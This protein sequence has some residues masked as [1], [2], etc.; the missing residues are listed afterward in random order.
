MKILHLID[1]MSSGGAQSL[2]LELSLVQKQ[3]GHDVSV[4]QLSDSPDRTF[5]VRLL[6]NSIPIAAL[7]KG[8]MYN[9]AH[10][11][12]IMP[13]LRK[14]D[15]VHVH[16]FPALYWS[17]LAN[18][19]TLSKTP[20]IYTEHSTQNKRRDKWYLNLAD[21]FIYK[22]CY[23][24]IIACADK[25]YETFHS[26]YS[27][28]KCITIPNGVDV[29]RYERA[30]PYNRRDLVDSLPDDA[31]LITMVARYSYPKK[32]DTIVDA[33]AKLP[34]RFHAIF[35]G[36]NET[37]LEAK[38]LRAYAESRGVADRVHSLYIRSDIPE[39][40]KTSDI[41]IMSS[42]Y[43]GLSLSSIEGMASGKP[44]LATNVNGLRD[45]VQGAGELFECGNSE[46]LAKLISKL[47][48]DRVFYNLVATRSIE[49][50]KKYDIYTTTKKY[51]N[52]YNQLI[53]RTL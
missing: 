48:S 10:I 39:I 8:S 34:S 20:L 21:R 15:V 33:I 41:V 18:L 43:E 24:T 13:H 26:Y 23:K 53:L 4:L 45:V 31:F 38:K 6:A 2:V 40:L 37:D 27:N 30:V 42:E 49:R 35:V 44:F 11:F 36:G 32:Q 50:A 22:N 1:R 47:E 3:M 51:M 46:E 28:I 9:P 16:L 52:V 19:L 12:R 29:D 25:A 7:S 17:G 14:Y 5:P